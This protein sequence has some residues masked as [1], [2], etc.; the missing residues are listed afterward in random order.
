MGTVGFRHRAGEILPRRLSTGVLYSFPDRVDDADHRHFGI[1][2]SF[3]LVLRRCHGSHPP[4]D[5]VGIRGLI[6]VDDARRTDVIYRD[7]S[8]PFSS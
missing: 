4:S 7:S 2:R 5:I 3:S 8:T 6:L 1:L